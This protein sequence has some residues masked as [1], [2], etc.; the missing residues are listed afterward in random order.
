MNKTIG[1]YNQFLC[2]DRMCGGHFVIRWRQAGV[3]HQHQNRAGQIQ[4]DVE[5]WRGMHH[6]QNETD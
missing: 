1:W 3:A 6:C 2:V 4:G 5:L